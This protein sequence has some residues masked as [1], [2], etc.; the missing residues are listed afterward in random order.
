MDDFYE[1]LIELNPETDLDIINDLNWNVAEK[2]SLLK[3]NEYA[4]E[5]MSSILY[6]YIDKEDLI[7]DTVTYNVSLEDGENTLH[8]SAFHEFTS[9][10]LT[11][12]I[13]PTA[14]VY[15]QTGVQQWNE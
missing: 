5:P 3:P 8:V 7:L 1:I 4:F 12:V 14:E 6:L 2:G 11:D 15:E 9:Y 10:M 13:E